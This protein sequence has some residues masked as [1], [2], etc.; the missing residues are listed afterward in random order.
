LD[1][2]PA[3]LCVVPGQKIIMFFL[4][5]GEACFF[6]PAE[7]KLT[8]TV[9]SLSKLI[10]TFVFRKSSMALL[11]TTRLRLRDSDRSSASAFCL[12][13]VTRAKPNSSS[14]H[15]SRAS[16]KDPRRFSMRP[17]LS[18][19]LR[20]SLAAMLLVTSSVSPS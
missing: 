5:S 20:R 4:Q 13:L 15:R 3:D 6:I 19:S 18:N 17:R 10:H 14:S 16:I 2:P 7:M 8:T 1:S 11:L 9:V 12:L